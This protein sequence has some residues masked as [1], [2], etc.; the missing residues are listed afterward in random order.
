MTRQNI[1]KRFDAVSYSRTF[2]NIIQS[3][4]MDKKKVLDIGCSYGEFLA[5]FGEGSTGLTVVLEEVEYGKRRGLN[6][7]LGNIEADDCGLGPG[8]EKFE[9]IF[10]NNIFEHLLSPHAFLQKIKAFLARDGFLILGV[11]C[12]PMIAFLMRFSRF[13][14]AAAS[15]HI[16][17]FT[18]H[19]L[20]L[21]IL[22][23]GWII[24]EARSFRFKNKFLDAFLHPIAPHF[25]V[26]ATPDPNFAYNKKRLKEL[27]GYGILN[28]ADAK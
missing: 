14:G 2:R 28:T 4:S 24:S 3:F 15:N 7:R 8:N 21:T 9:I 25:Y 6:V 5:H 23:G 16:N 19:T 27:A 20:A 22:S 10:A 13:R 18:R 17:F 1:E 11:P 26:I 12:V